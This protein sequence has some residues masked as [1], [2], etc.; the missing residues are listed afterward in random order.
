MLYSYA[1]LALQLLLAI[2]IVLQ[3]DIVYQVLLF[4][5]FSLLVA[6]FFF[7]NGVTNLGIFVLLLF[8]A[9]VIAM[10]LIATIFVPERKLYINKRGFL[11][12]LPLFLVLLLLQ[13][14]VISYSI[15]I[16]DLVSIASISLFTG[17][18]IVEKR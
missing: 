7:L 2:G 5:I 17:W 9:G 18:V 15:N 12:F 4:F 16:V 13:S 14:N 11:L 3:R 1:I 6:M 8:N 10:L